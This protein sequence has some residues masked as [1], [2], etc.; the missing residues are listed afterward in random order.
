MY[1]AKH[2]LPGSIQFFADEMNDRAKERLALERELRLAVDRREFELHYQPQLAIDRRRLVGV[3][4]LV[5]WRHPTRGLLSPAS[6]VQV[7]EENGLICDIGRQV[8]T[9]GCR[10][11]RSWSSLDPTL[12]LSVN[13]SVV[14]LKADDGLVDFVAGTMRHAGL[15]CGL[16]E[17]E[18]TEGL[19]LDPRLDIMSSKLRELTEAG[20]KLSIDD[21]GTGYSS[22]AYLRSFPVDRIKIDRTFVKGVEEDE[23]A[24]A[25]VRSIIG[26]GHS[27]GKP[28]TA[29]GVETEAQLGFLQRE[30]C[31]EAQGYLL[32]RPDEAASI[33][34]W[35]H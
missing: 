11:L 32:G 34:R 9:D 31:D 23:Q 8:L 15:D 20:I 1:R 2:A 16:L 33:D 18:V 27:L 10:Q 28:I 12:R 22:L 13:L 14:Q 7:A 17:L 5:R 25:I 19:F 3:E 26:L 6:F 29:E 24:C 4:C 30:R 21:F 35:L